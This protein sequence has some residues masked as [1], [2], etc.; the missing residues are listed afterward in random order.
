MK[1]ILNIIIFIMSVNSYQIYKPS[2]FNNKIFYPNYKLYKTYPILSYSS[3]PKFPKIT[4]KNVYS[5]N[6]SKKKENKKKIKKLPNM[7][8]F[9]NKLEKI[10]IKCLY[11]YM[12][13][14]QSL[15]CFPL[16]FVFKFNFNNFTNIY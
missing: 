14:I 6:L 7:F 12:L 15:H 10:I 1:I 11:N 3:S 4:F 16:A 5:T 2:I 9:L 8:I 13:S